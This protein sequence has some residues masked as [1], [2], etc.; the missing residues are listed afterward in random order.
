[1]QVAMQALG[2][3]VRVM[4]QRMP[5]SSRCEVER[6]GQRAF[7]FLAAAPFMQVSMQALGRPARAIRGGSAH[8]GGNAG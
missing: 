5:P 6:L 2:G 1:M 4:G 8:A 3:P 7:G